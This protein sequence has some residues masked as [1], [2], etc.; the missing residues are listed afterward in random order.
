MATVDFDNAAEFLAE[1][2]KDRQY[3]DRGIVRISQCQ[4]HVGTGFIQRLS[5]T[6]TSRVGADIYRYHVFC[7]ALCGIPESDQRALDQQSE[8]LSGLKLGC[9]NLGLD[10]RAG[11]LKE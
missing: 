1:L 5:V 8:A 10:A 2:E 3:V 4:P 6:A 9:T 7:G 11:E